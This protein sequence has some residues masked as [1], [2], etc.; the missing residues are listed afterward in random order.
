MALTIVTYGGGEVLEKIFIAIAMLFNKEG[1]GIIRSI[2]MMGCLIS[3][4]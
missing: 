4:L 3:G 2:M 1:Q